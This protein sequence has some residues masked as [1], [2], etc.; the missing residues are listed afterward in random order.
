MHASEILRPEILSGPY[1]KVREEVPTSSGSNHFLV[2]SDFGVFEAEGNEMLLRRVNEIN[3]IARLREVSRTDEFKHAL[4]KAAKSPLAT[5]KALVTDPVHTV[6][7]IPKGIMK[8]MG[9]AGET[10]KHAGKKHGEGSSGGVDVRQIIGFTDTKRKVAISLGVDPYSTNRVLQ[11]ELD[12]IAWASFAGD[13]AF[14]V[15]TMPIGGPLGTALTTTQVVGTFQDALR[16]KSPADLKAMN[17]KLLLGIGASNEDV[18]RL[19]S[20]AAF[21]P[22]AQTAFALNLRALDGVANRGAFVRLAGKTSASEADA[23]F[24]VQ[25]A[26]LMGRLHHGEKP[27]SRIVLLGDFP[28][29]IAKDGSTFVAL[30]WDYAAYTYSADKFARDLQASRIGKT[31]C[32]IAL[33]GVIS[34]HLRQV[35]EA[36]GNMIQDRLVPGPLK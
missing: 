29:C 19:L 18:E 35:L 11:H 36:R 26:A 5:A 4:E 13:L 32:F 12:G 31:P 28:L 1:H 25:T 30:Q 20:N 8:F 33:S 17:K 16:E 34:P 23:I 22:S 7:A 6:E 3:A 2:D 24:C 21:S 9:R 14:N 27:L 10:I 15:G